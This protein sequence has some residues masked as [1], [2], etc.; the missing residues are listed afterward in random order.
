MDGQRR[1]SA[2]IGSRP[3]AGVAVSQRQPGL[4]AR[5]FARPRPRHAGSRREQQMLRRCERISRGG[6]AL[7]TVATLL[8]SVSYGGHWPVVRSAI[9]Q[10]P[11]AIASMV[12]FRVQQIVVSGQMALTTQEIVDAVGLDA[13]R[14]IVFL[15]VNIARDQLLALPLVETAS[16]RKYYP[17]RVEITVTERQPFAVWQ[18]GGDFIVISQDGTG[19]DTVRDGRYAALPLVVGAGADKAAGEFL[20]LLAR[21]PDVV[22]ETY[23][24]VRVGERRWNLRLNNGVDVKLPEEGVESALEHVADLLQDGD[25]LQRDL[26]Y[27]DVRDVAHTIVRLTPEA[28]K[29]QAEMAKQAGRRTGGAT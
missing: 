11:D 21:Y 4:L 14:S 26:V 17:G 5:F 13:T 24:A 29:A 28:V 23:G 18:H 15:D 6:L 3:G 27:I 22:R 12:G 19:I 25:L 7:F 8:G 2:K 9:E 20:P 10:T 1:I 16:V